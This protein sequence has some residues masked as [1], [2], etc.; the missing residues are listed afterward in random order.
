MPLEIATFNLSS[1]ILALTVPTVTRIELC[2]SFSVGGLTPELSTFRSLA[3]HR[4]S[5]SKAEKD[6]TSAKIVPIHVMIRPHA[7]DFFYTQEEVNDMAQDIEQFNDEGADGFVFGCLTRGE[8][9]LKI[10]TK[11]CTTLLAAASGKKLL[12]T[13]HSISSRRPPCFRI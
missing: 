7:R 10:D 6:S 1:A 9:G 8:I 5:L 11:A 4:R 12:S 3:A 13:E 2:F